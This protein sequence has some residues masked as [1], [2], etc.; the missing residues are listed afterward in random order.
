MLLAAERVD[1]AIDAVTS[2]IAVRPRRALDGRRVHTRGREGRRCRWLP[3]PQRVFA[4][5]VAVTDGT[6]GCR[7]QPCTIQRFYCAANLPHRGP[8]WP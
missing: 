3:T 2:E 5:T 6:T 7:N 8:G 1:S 4:F